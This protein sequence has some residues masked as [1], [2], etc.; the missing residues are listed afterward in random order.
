MNYIQL[1]CILYY[2]DYLSL[3]ETSKPVTDTCKYF[4][5]HK[6]PVNC[7]YIAGY[8]PEFDENDQYIQ[9]AKEQYEK[10]QDF[11]DEESAMT[12]ID[13][14]CF[15]RACGMVDAVRMLQHI[16]MFS[17]KQ[18]RKQAFSA[19]YQWEKS[20]NYTHQIYDENGNPKETSCTKYFKHAETLSERRKLHEST[21]QNI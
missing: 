15:L 7:A 14:I 13:D 18:E 19:Y 10:I 3:K 6:C 16:H 2:A 9:Q 17:S 8:A 1:N 4:F 5:V 20:K 12:F 21:E 11:F